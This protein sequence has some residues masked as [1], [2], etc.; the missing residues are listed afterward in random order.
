[1]GAAAATW[2]VG[3]VFKV[4]GITLGV[5]IIASIGLILLILISFLQT[6]PTSETDPL[7]WFGNMFGIVNIILSVFFY[8]S[9]L[10]ATHH[11]VH[12]HRSSFKAL[13]LQN[14]TLRLLALG[15]LVGIGSFVLAEGIGMILLPFAGANPGNEQLS[16]LMNNPAVLT[17]LIPVATIV[18]PLVEEIYFRGFAYS[19]FRKRWGSRTGTFISA[20]MFAVVHL[21]PWSF[22]P[23][24][25][26]GIVFAYA[27]EKTSSLPLVI[28]AHGVFNAIAFTLT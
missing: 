3:D 20:I 14:A 21:D 15:F 28:V 8:G 7:T 2:S 19:A 22:I 5:G 9:G 1:M 6:Y 26:I 27:Y 4:A 18:A 25:V 23:I 10:L 16:D 17:T 24:A 11:Y 12:E 13:G